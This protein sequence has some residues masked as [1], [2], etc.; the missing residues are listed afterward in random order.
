MRSS[1]DK[2]PDTEIKLEL[3]NKC[4]KDKVAFAF[5]DRPRLVRLRKRLGIYTFDCNVEGRD[6]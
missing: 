2:R 1:R 6:F 5:D 4:L 3:Y